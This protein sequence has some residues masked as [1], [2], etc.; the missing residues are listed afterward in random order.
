MST[1]RIHDKDFEQFISAAQIQER[2]TQLGVMLNTDYFDKRP[3]F[4]GVLNGAFLFMADL[5]KHVSVEC[6]LSFIKLSSYSGT[7]T[8]GQVKEMIGLNHEITGRDVVIIEDIV[9]TGDTAMYLTRELKKKNPTSIRF[10]TLLL[11]PKALKQD[12]KPDYT[13]FEIEPDFVVGYGLDYDGLGRNL[14]DIY[15]LQK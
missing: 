9:D 11:K 13:G 1:I 7:E 8:T 2:V 5:I 12:F 6:E 3:V 15:R 10:A 4:I 14:N